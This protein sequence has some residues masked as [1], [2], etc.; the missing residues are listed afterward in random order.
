MVNRLQLTVAR[1][2]TCNITINSVPLK[3]LRSRHQSFLPLFSLLPNRIP[4][5]FLSTSFLSLALSIILSLIPYFLSP[6]AS[7]ANAPDISTESATAS[8]F[9]VRRVLFSG[10]R[11]PLLCGCKYRSLVKQ[12]FFQC[13]LHALRMLV[14]CLF[15]ALLSF[16]FRALLAPLSY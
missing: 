16:S 3:T 1:Q 9:T 7:C 12:V 5:F 6:R 15:C 8:P 14:T 13:S 11:V 4:S 2:D 10:L